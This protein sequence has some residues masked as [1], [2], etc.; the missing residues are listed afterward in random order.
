MQVEK[1][2]YRPLTTTC[3][4]AYWPSLKILFTIPKTYDDEHASN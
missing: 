1:L 2:G 4:P 3:I